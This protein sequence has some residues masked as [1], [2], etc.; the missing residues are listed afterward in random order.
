MTPEEF[1]LAKQRLI[2]QK[3]DRID[4][5]RMCDSI[6][7]SYESGEI[8]TLNAHWHLSVN[9]IDFSC[10]REQINDDLLSEGYTLIPDVEVESLLDSMQDGNPELYRR[11]SLFGKYWSDYKICDVINHWQSDTRLIPPTI[12]FN[13]L[14]NKIYVAEGKHRLN[15]AYFFGCKVLPI[16]VPNVYLPQVRK[17][18]WP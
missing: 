3:A 14:L 9:D 13:R 18:I 12:I 2:K 4:F 6:K 7:K 15:V 11:K 1:E 5:N 10:Q 17:L 16:I 8:L